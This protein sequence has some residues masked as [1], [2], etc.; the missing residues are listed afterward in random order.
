MII[1]FTNRSALRQRTLEL[2]NISALRSKRGLLEK[3]AHAYC[4]KNGE[5]YGLFESTGSCPVYDAAKR[6]LHALQ[7]IQG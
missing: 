2:T 6:E 1:H 4:E 7:L 5:P 3:F